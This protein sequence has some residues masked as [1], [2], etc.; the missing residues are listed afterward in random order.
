MNWSSTAFFL[1]WSGIC[2]QGITQ[3]VLSCHPMPSLVHMSPP[4]LL[5]FFYTSSP[6]RRIGRIKMQWVV[7]RWQYLYHTPSPPPNTLST[8]NRL[9]SQLPPQVYATV[10]EI[11]RC[12]LQN[13]LSVWMVVNSGTKHIPWVVLTKCSVHTYQLYKDMATTALLVSSLVP[14]PDLSQG[15][16]S[17]D[18]DWAISW[19]CWVSSIEHWLHAWMT[20]GLFHWLMHTLRWCGTIPLAFTKSRLLTPHNQEIAQ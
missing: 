9:P 6:R 7:L 2:R 15:K 18:T 1:V 12:D 5:S 8:S 10:W 14:R 17:G 19:L 11:P 3:R 20:Y 16:R 13:S 4:S